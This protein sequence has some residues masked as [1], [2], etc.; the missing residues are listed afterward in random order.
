MN[1]SNA[2]K[3]QITKSDDRVLK[4][5]TYLSAYFGGEVFHQSHSRIANFLKISVS[6]VRRAIKKLTDLGIV[7]I[8]HDDGQSN[9]YQIDFNRLQDLLNHKPKNSISLLDL[10]QNS[11]I[12]NAQPTIKTKFDRYGLKDDEIFERFIAWKTANDAWLERIYSDD[13]MLALNVSLGMMNWGG[14]DA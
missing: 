2:T 11:V 10:F 1:V 8:Q 4:Q 6:T 3:L 14:F 5:F 9:Y 7:L 13:Y 12:V